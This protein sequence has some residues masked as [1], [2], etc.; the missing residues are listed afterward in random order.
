EPP[1]AAAPPADQEPAP[2]TS[3]EPG[4]PTLTAKAAPAP[5]IT[6]PVVELRHEW[7]SFTSAQGLQ[8]SERKVRRLFEQFQKD[9]PGAGALRFLDHGDGTVTDTATGLTWQKDYTMDNK[10]SFALSL[11]EEANQKRLGGFAD[12][13]L[14]T[15]EELFFLYLSVEA[16]PTI[17]LDLPGKNEGLWSSDKITI[18]GQPDSGYAFA[19]FYKDLFAEGLALKVPDP[20]GSHTS[21]H[22]KAVRMAK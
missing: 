9:Y 19:W 4:A 6:K 17:P 2:P 13:R 10:A 11:A 5:G 14:P 15:T 8:Q 12:W 16:D 21:H 3:T 20:S 1:V 22:V 18:L 7:K